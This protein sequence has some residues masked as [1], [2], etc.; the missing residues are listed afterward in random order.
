MQLR[1]FSFSILC[2]PDCT[3]FLNHKPEKNVNVLTPHLYLLSS[4]FVAKPLSGIGNHRNHLPSSYF[5][6][7][8]CLFRFP[9]LRYAVI[10]ASCVHLT[11]AK[12]A[13]ISLVQRAPKQTMIQT[14]EE[15]MRQGREV[16]EPSPVVVTV[17]ADFT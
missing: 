5:Y 10:G 1:P 17:D 9:S 4:A 13:K 3:L 8:A 12:T 7:L 15:E 6:S 2:F 11:S 14:W 16:R